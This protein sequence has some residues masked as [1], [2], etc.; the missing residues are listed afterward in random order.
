VDSI[1]L[2][3]VKPFD[4]NFDGKTEFQVPA[5]DL[6]DDDF[7]IG[8]IVGPSGS[9]KSTLLRS[10]GDES[11][12]E[13]HSGKTVASHFQSATD[14]IDRLCGVGLNSIPS[15]AKPYQV[16]STGEKFRADLARAL[17]DGAI[18]D[19]F[20]STV[21]RTVAKATSVAVARFVRQRG[22]K[23]VVFA[24]CHYD[25]AEWLQPDWV[26]DTR[27]QKFLPRGSLQ[28]RPEINLEILPCGVEAWAA[29]CQHHYLT[30]ALNKAARCWLAVWNDEPVAF[31]SAL[32]M[33]QIK[34]AWREHRTVVF[35]DFQ[36]LG[37]G[38]RCSDAIGEMFLADGCRYFSKTAHPRMGQYRERSPAWKATTKN[39]VIRSDY[40]SDRKTKESNYKQAHAHRDCYS[41]EYIGAQ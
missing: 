40:K 14:A 33:P 17:N 5:F 15:W 3:A 19:E 4:F 25:I 35:P 2:D 10:I 30:G 13:W 31:M 23:R 28:P 12:H 27:G 36:G 32:A 18:V 29:F 26:Y 16:L 1:T 24:S 37:I 41:H 20:T 11:A 38:V 34:T 6:P 8:L 21:D 39:R 7:S 22:F 9:G